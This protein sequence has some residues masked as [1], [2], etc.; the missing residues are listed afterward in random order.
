MGELIR[1]DFAGR[2]RIVRRDGFLEAAIRCERMAGQ[3]KS[4]ADSLRRAAARYRAR[5]NEG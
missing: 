4:A 5:A 3:D 1:V 2:N